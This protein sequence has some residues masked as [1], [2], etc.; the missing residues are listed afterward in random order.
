MIRNRL[1]SNYMTSNKSYNDLLTGDT[2]EDL[3]SAGNH[4]LLDFQRIASA[5]PNSHR[6]KSVS[7]QSERD[8]ENSSQITGAFDK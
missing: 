4:G 6:K 5:E 2:N 7:H 1:A 8:H 3:S